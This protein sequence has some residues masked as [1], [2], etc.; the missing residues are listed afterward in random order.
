MKRCI[1]IA[2][3]WLYSSYLQTLHRTYCHSYSAYSH[4]FLGHHFNCYFYL[5][6]FCH[7]SLPLPVSFPFL[8]LCQP[9]NPFY[10]ICQPHAPFFFY[11]SLLTLSV[12]TTVQVFSHPPPEPSDTLPASGPFL[13]PL[14]A[15]SPFCSFS[16]LLY[17]SILFLCQPPFPSVSSVSILPFRFPLLASYSF[18]LLCQPPT[19]SVSLPASCPFC[20]LC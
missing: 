1:G 4:I 6:T 9:P 19:L 16:S 15:S 17:F 11:A 20:H 10:Y 18:M 8:S 14:P 5:P 3:P 12:T 13:F 2:Q 7:L